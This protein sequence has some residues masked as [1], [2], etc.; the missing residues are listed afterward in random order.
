M[1]EVKPFVFK[2]FI[3]EQDLVTM[4]VGTDGVLVAAWA[5]VSSADQVMDIGTGSGVIALIL[6]QRTLPKAIIHSIDVDVNAIKQAAKN[7]SQSP[8]PQKFILHHSS[9]QEFA[10]TS[11]DK[12]DL[13][14]SNPP[15][16][17]GGMLSENNDRND[18]RH[19][20]K[21][22]HGDLLLAVS[23]LL[24]PT[25][26]L[27]IILPYLQGLRFIEISA[28]YRFYPARITEVKSRTDKPTERLLIQFVKQKCEIEKREL[29][30]HAE[31]DEYTQEYKELTKDFYLKF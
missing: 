22:P 24:R 30:I 28:S 5:E 17:T 13:I 3:V 7:F 23:R 18:V 15:F 1:S 4:K 19:T 10:R 12:F 6:A 8:W 11:N 9:I 21:L 29:I 31:G 14:I 27:V 2:Q 20:T 16:F 25:G 26:S